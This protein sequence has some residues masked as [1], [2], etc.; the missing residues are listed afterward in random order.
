VVATLTLI[1]GLLTGYL[2]RIEIDAYHERQ[3]TLENFTKF[4]SVVKNRKDA[5]E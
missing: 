4:M 5:D 2:I 3:E 1:I